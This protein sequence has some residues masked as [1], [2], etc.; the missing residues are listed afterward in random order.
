MRRHLRHLI[1]IEHG[2]RIVLDLSAEAFCGAQRAMPHR[3]HGKHNLEAQ[4]E[5][6]VAPRSAPEGDRPGWPADQQ[7]GR[8]A[9]PEIAPQIVHASVLA[10]SRQPM[11]L[12]WK[13]SAKSIWSTPRYARALAFAKVSATAVTARTRPP[14]ATRPSGPSAVPAWKTVTPS[15]CSAAS[16]ARISPPLAGVPG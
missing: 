3:R 9:G 5:R 13:P 8:E 16:M 4:R 7:P 6:R 11:S 1:M 15:T 12:R 14:L 10:S 2:A